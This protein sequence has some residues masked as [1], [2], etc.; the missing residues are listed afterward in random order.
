MIKLIRYMGKYKKMFLY[1]FLLVMVDVVCEM[2][3]PR[4]MAQIV[5]VAL[6]N[7]DRARI[8]ML[9]AVMVLLALAAIA[10]GMGNMWLSANASH[11]F[12]A[13]LRQTLFN[14][15][16]QFSFQNIDAF[17]D[18]SL[19]TRLT[20]DITQIQFA[21]MMTMRMLMRAPLM[22]VISSIFAIRI[23]WELSVIIMVAVPVLGIG[24]AAMMAAVSK[25]FALMQKRLDN[26]NADVQENLT[27]IR[28]VK[29]FV[30]EGY[31]KMK[32][33]NVNNALT[34][35]GMKA[36]KLASIGMPLMNLV[37]NG[38][39]IAAFLLGGR[40]TGAGNMGVGDFQSFITYMMQILFSVMMFSMGILM[41]ARSRASVKRVLEVLQTEVTIRDPQETSKIKAAPTVTRGAIVFEDVSF[42]YAAGTSEGENVL[43]HINLSIQPGEYIA[44]AGGTGSGKT[45][46]VNLIPRLYDVLE[47]RVLVDGVDVRDYR[48]DDLRAGIGVVLQK[49]MLFSGTVRENLMWGDEHAT[50]QQIQRAAAAAQAEDF[51][52]QRPGGYDSVIEQGGVN[53]S[54]GQRQRLCIARAILKNPRIL[55]LDDSLSAVDTATE[56]KIRQAL[57]TEFKGT[58][59]LAVTQRVSAMQQADRIVVLDDGRIAGVGTHEQL[60]ASNKVYQEI[61]ASQQEG[62]VS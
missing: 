56:A 43:Q 62:L 25:L 10:L 30:R 58:T 36:G 35:A 22:L 16:G 39:L 48:L 42:R 26:L 13:N 5:D 61:C 34:E 15:L 12:A 17:S 33:A 38:A 50:Q 3:I 55:I 52:L 49:N 18:A 51:I 37:F 14:K 4:L 40:I 57:A 53:V 59:V 41:V 20:N 8:Y 21:M 28:V 54:G 60:S 1:S 23:N 11:G 44:I 27:A 24:V 46:L 32:F 9:G 47:G 6:P 19:I 2:A 29:A 7:G 31:E 45:T